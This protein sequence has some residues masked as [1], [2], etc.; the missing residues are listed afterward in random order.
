[1]HTKAPAPI[2]TA[3]GLD[4]LT[5]SPFH[6]L[7]AFIDTIFRG[8]GQVMLQNNTYAGI[9]FTIGIFYNSLLFGAAVLT[10]T[11]ASTTTAILLG[12]D[13]A[14][15]RNG[16]FGFNG[17]LVTIALLYFLEPSALT[18]GYVLLAAAC[19]TIV[20]AA[21]MNVFATWKVPALTAPFVL[22]TLIFI[23]AYAR[24][25]RLNSTGLL[26]TAGLPKLAG[27]VEG[28]VTN[29]TIT[30]GILN[31]VAQVFFQANPITG[32]I[33]LIALFVSSRLAATAALTG[34]TIGLLTA[35]LL[36]AAEPAIRSGAFGF[37]SVLT[38][39]AIASVFFVLNKSSATYT[40]LATI[41]T[42]VMFAAISAT[43]EPLGMP[44]M[45][46]PFVITTWLFL[47]AAALFP[48]LQPT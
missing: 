36:G 2:L 14:H 24:F 22:T 8:I 3:T 11:I 47:L 1:M 16:L 4:N 12:V 30:E 6:K 10:G 5:N 44:A 34:S 19:S 21:L 43:L 46:A 31:G 15:I 18:A 45:T 35:W 7:L 39:I 20:M 23:L 17:A 41:A 40:L 9:L 48:R 38:A 28:I 26:P 27:T 13:R 37:N 32:A 25:G 33:F 29:T 42:A